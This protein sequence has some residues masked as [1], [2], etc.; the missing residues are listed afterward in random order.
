MC[1]AGRVQT[2]VAMAAMLIVE[3]IT[4]HYEYPCR[5][6]KYRPR[7]EV[8]KWDEACREPAWDFNS[9]GEIV[10]HKSTVARTVMCRQDGRGD[11]RFCWTISP[12][13]GQTHKENPNLVRIL[14][15]VCTLNDIYKQYNKLHEN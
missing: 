2:L 9:E 11:F 8:S 15:M 12:N 13:V 6:I 1:G 5:I 10:T 3:N 7:A 4:I 14:Y